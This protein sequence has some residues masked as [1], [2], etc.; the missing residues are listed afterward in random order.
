MKGTGPAG[1]AVT[2]LSASSHGVECSMGPEGPESS[3]EG[4]WLLP[5]AAPQ[6]AALLQSSELSQSH[7]QS[8]C[9]PRGF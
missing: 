6:F 7:Y 5:P 8:G 2:V 9:Q 1:P 3:S 4:L